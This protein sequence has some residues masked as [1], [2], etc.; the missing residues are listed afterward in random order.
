M[1]GRGGQSP[2]PLGVPH[3]PAE[4]V[5]R[6]SRT[7]RVVLVPPP[8]HRVVVA[9]GGGVRADPPPAAGSSRR[10]RRGRMSRGRGGD[11]RARAGASQLP[12]APTAVDG[13]P[14]LDAGN[15]ARKDMR[16]DQPAGGGPPA[17]PRRGADAALVASSRLAPRSPG[18]VRNR[19]PCKASSCSPRRSMEALPSTM[20]W[21]VVPR[22]DL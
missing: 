15:R 16:V 17:H 14:L 4:Y 12:K 13:G 9:T 3:A 6:G 20:V 1:W 2:S 5:P 19:C 21:T 18:G 10:L 8:L 11:P 22:R 7:T